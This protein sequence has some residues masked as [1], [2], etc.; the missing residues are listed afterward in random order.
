MFSVAPNPNVTRRL[1]YAGLALVTLCYGTVLIR[2]IMLI[3]VYNLTEP[4][5]IEL[6]K[7]MNYAEERCPAQTCVKQE[8][9]TLYINNAQEIVEHFSF[10]TNC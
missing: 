8:F 3:Y 6:R 2:A 10:G 1:N 5:H 9:S 4:S 7:V